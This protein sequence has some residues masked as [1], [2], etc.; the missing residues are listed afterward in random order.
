MKFKI[1]RA[2]LA[3][4]LLVTTALCQR[5][6]AQ[7]G[8]ATQWTKDGYHYYDTD[9][10]SI[11][12]IDARDNSKKTI[13]SKSKLHLKG[14]D[15]V[16]ITRF[17]VSDDGQ[18][19]LISNNTKKVWRYNTRG[20]YWLYDMRTGKLRQL[21]VKRPASSLMFAKLSPDGSKVAYVSG[22][23]IFVEDVTTGTVKQ[24]TTDGTTKL[25]NGTFDWAYEE[26]LDCRDGFR[27]SPDSRSIAYW[28][29]D[30]RKIRNYLMLNTTDSAYSYTVPVEYPIVGTDPSSAKIGVVNVSTAKTTW[31][32]IP[33][34]PVQ[35][36][37]PRMEWAGNSNELIVQ[38]L[39]RAQN[40]SN[41]IVCNVS[42]AT[43]HVIYTDKD[44][45]WVDAKDEAIGWDWIEK[46]KAFVWTTEKDGWR[47]LY[48][49]DREGNEKLLTPG[50]YDVISLS[51]I[52][53]ANGYI[54]FIASPDNATQKYLYRVSIKGS[55]TP[56]RIT[57]MDQPGTHN[58]ELSP[59]GKLAIH[60]FSNIYT[61]PVTEIIN[62]PQ[63]QHI[64]GDLIKIDPATAKSRTEFFKVK[65]Q[66]GVDMDGWMVK[67]TNFDPAKK[68]PIVFYVYGEP[69]SQTVT[70]RYGASNNRLYDGSV[71]ND[72][73]IYVS[74]DNRGSP[75]PKG[76]EWRKSIYRSIGTLNIRDQAMAAKEILKWPYVD[77][78]RVAVWGWSGG[79]SSTLN[80][81]FQ[82][83]EI[84][85]T[86]IAV[87]AVG[88]QLTYD[89]I[90]EE[91]YMGVP[92][93]KESRAYYVKGSPI[94]YAKNLR[95][96][97]LYIHG[98][99]DDNVHYANAE[100]LIN[101]FIKYNRQFQL[102]SYPNRT[103][104]IREGE[105]TTEHLRTLCTQYLREHCPPG[106]R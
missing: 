41:I 93:D 68:Y 89:N 76:R 73:Y 30:A 77:T 102:M 81:L 95:G 33:G 25:I 66:D 64:S 2:G 103:H 10:G 100:Q 47:H 90:Y 44:K 8:A 3:A 84:Y 72:G 45:A 105:G 42:N 67:P 27:W 86:G 48:R 79:G 34:D 32:K 16:G 5:A 99:G 52:D 92:I 4:V 57:P 85:K 12:S 13:L 83:P 87:A 70:D 31:M 53:E 1:Y 46:G 65:T 6:H 97:L 7:Y 75:A 19:I 36:Y 39:N 62:L 35:H 17:T 88:N 14:K 78:S 55:T 63:H 60:N 98:T 106:G 37:L 49:V 69:A 51:L 58:Y 23:N 101:Q 18:K 96:N 38:Q 74:V 71:A 104:S 54:Y 40:E 28:Q 29:I 43:A 61:K 94:T 22:H 56:D 59:N 80:L 26:E 21:G 9:N 91:R 15:T 20:D 50:K 24:L 11:V 82:Y